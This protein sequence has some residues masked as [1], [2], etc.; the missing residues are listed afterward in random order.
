M[1]LV[2]SD[3]VDAIGYAI[4]ADCYAIT[5]RLYGAMWSIVIAGFE[6]PIVSG[7]AVDSH[8]DSAYTPLIRA[9]GVPP[10][11]RYQTS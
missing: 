5:S 3:G 10:S 7:D 6:G 8:S 4:K 1:R 11:F 9:G 2:I